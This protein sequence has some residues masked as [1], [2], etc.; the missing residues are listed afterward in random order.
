MKIQPIF[1]NYNRVALNRSNINQTKT[2][3]QNTVSF[4]SKVLSYE[5]VKPYRLKAYE[6]KQQSQVNLTQ[7]KNI[8]SLAKRKMDCANDAYQYALQVAREVIKNPKAQRIELG[9]NYATF[10]FKME[11]NGLAIDIRVF[12]ENNKRLRDILVYNLKIKSVLNYTD[13]SLGTIYQFGNDNL[14]ISE[15]MTLTGANAGSCDTHYNFIE[16]EL[17]LC[18]LNATFENPQKA[19]KT[20]Y[21]KGDKLLSCDIDDQ[22]MLPVFFMVSSERFMYQ[23]EQLVN[24]LSNF[25]KT[26]K[27]ITSWEEGY[28]FSNGSFIGYSEKTLQPILDEN[29]TCQNAIFKVG[30][31]FVESDSAKLSFDI[32]KPIEFFN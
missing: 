16:G 23:D 32:S 24:Y 31:D 13:D 1:Y 5:E 3:G 9:K 29:L 19:Q 7:A 17:A 14:S 26:S 22:L 11:N 28:H 25:H 20:F 15:N 2:K 8:Q 6:L 27:G 12:D 30:D 21:F 18:K 4:T 10:K